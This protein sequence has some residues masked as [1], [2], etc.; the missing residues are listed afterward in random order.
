MPVLSLCRQATGTRTENS[1]ETSTLFFIAVTH[2]HQR[3]SLPALTARPTSGIVIP[4]REGTSMTLYHITFIR[5]SKWAIIND[6]KNDQLKKA[7]IHD[8]NEKLYS[9]YRSTISKKNNDVREY[10]RKISPKANKR[11]I[12]S[13]TFC[14]GYRYDTTETKCNLCDLSIH[15]D[16]F[17]LVTMRQKILKKENEMENNGVVIEKNDSGTVEHVIVD[18]TWAV[19]V[20]HDEK[21]PELAVEVYHVHDGGDFWH[22][23]ICWPEKG[24]QTV[25]KCREC[26]IEVPSG[27]L[28]YAKTARL[29]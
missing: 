17:D 8:F 19:T 5:D 11:S 4:S 12:I 24:T 3:L 16:Y 28:T 26:S 10:I 14:E 29:R 27:I 2:D 25:Y 13:V 6:L 7:H 21:N 23:Q 15:R 18:D 1:K 20:R 22:D 9:H